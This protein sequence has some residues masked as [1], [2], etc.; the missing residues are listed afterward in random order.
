M[1]IYKEKN[2]SE[3]TFVLEEVSFYECSLKDCDLFYSGGDFE[4]VNTKMDNCR[5]HFRGAAKNTVGL[6]QML[7]M[8]P[9]PIQLPPQ[10]SSQAAPN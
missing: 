3:Q 6:M 7:R 9:G 1:K 8:L 4:M 5:M 2:M 10:T